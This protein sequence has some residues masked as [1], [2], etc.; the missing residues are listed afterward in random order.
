[1]LAL[2]VGAWVTSA[3]HAQAVFNPAIVDAGNSAAGQYTSMA[4]V[5]GKPAI[6]CYDAAAGDLK[7][8][9]NSAAD[10]SGT[11]IVTTVDTGVGSFVG[12]YTSLAV[13]GGKPA[14]SY[15]NNSNSDLKFA[16]NSAADGSGTWL[17]TTVDNTGGVGRYT[18]L[19]VLAD[20]T[21]AISYSDSTNGDLK[22]AR[23]SAADGSGAWTIVTVDNSAN[24]V[25]A[26]TSLAIVNGT[27]AISYHDATAGDLKF[28]RNS[29]ADGSGAWTIVTVDNSANFVGSYTSLAVIGGNPAISYYDSSVGELKYAW[30]PNSTG[31]GAWTILSVDGNGTPPASSNTVGQYTSLISLNGGPAISYY[32]TTTHDLKIARNSAAN[33]SGTW[34]IVTVESAGDVGSYTSLEIIGGNPAISHHDA[35]NGD[36][37]FGRNSAAD[38]SGTWSSTSIEAGPPGVAGEYASQAVIGGNPAMSYYDTAT[39]DLKFAR[40]S[41]ADGS[42]TWAITGVDG[43]GIAP[44]T[45]NTVGLYTSLAVLGNGLPAISYNN[46]SSGDLK[47]ARNSAADGSG[48]WTLSTPDTTGNVGQYT[49]LA[50]VSGNPA[51]TYYDVGNTSLKFARNAAADGSGTWAIATLDTGAVATDV[52]GLYT[53]LAALSGSGNPAISYYDSTNGALKFARNSAADGSGTWTIV[54]VD[55]GGTNDVGQYTSLAIV[56]GNPAISYYDA[57]AGDLKYA[58]NSAADGSGTWTILPVDTGGT[59]DVGQTNSLKVVNGVPAISYYDFTA[60]DLKYVRATNADGT[61]WATPLTVETANTV[62][63][64]SSLA[65]LANG[66]PAIGYWD[67]THG[68]LRWAGAINAAEI[69]VEQ[70]AGTDL[71]DGTS[72]DFGV[73]PLGSSTSL[74]FTLKN[75]GSGPLTLDPPVLTGTRP[76]DFAVNTTGT[77]L[78]IPGGGQTTF[79]VTFTPTADGSRSATLSFANNDADENPFNFF[80]VGSTG[81]TALSPEIAVEQPAGTDLID[82][83]GSIIFETTAVGG[84]SAA[85]VFTVKNTGT[86]PLALDA[87]T[88]SGGNPGDFVVD[89][90]G[91]ARIL[92]ATTGQTTFA[93]TFTP[94]A[95]GTRTTSLRIANNDFN[96]SSFDIALYG[97]NTDLIPPTGGTVVL[98]PASPFAPSTSLNVLFAGWTDPGTPLSYEVLVDSVI[99][100]TRSTS[101]SRTFT[102]P[103]TPGLHTLTGRI[104]DALNNVTE[105]T[106]NFT[107]IAPEIAIEQPAGTNLIDSTATIISFGPGP[108]GSPSAAKIFTVKNTGTAPLT[109]AA[110]VVSGTEASD[111]VVDTTGTLLVVPAG[112]QTTFAITF[113]P[114]AAGARSASVSITNNDT[115]EN[116]FNFTV[117]GTGDTAPPNNNF[118]NAQILPG[119]SGTVTGGNAGATQESGEPSHEPNGN[120]GGASVWYQW[121]APFTGT[122]TIDTIGSNFDTILGVYT[123]TA[124]G[125]LTEVVKDDDSGGSNT[126][127]VTFNATSGTVYRIA[128]DGFNRGSGPSTGSITL[129]Y[130]L[131]VPNDNFANAQIL[132]GSSGTVTG[133]NAGATQEAGEPFTGGVSVWYQ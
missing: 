70:P 9:R 125:S 122:A 54:T 97:N 41:A 30:A 65:V 119:S 73:V 1:M 43:T 87:F 79:S 27:P 107:V 124:V 117:T 95:T 5:A 49:S 58:R 77:L 112:G 81:S 115:N 84:S 38:G 113:T 51:I 96:E 82:G 104:Y 55:T 74:T 69:A 13:V 118:A 68:D 52:V 98:T 61:A 83:A 33:G 53:S 105:V 129:N 56:N 67:F 106:Q 71:A 40:N 32:D 17:L 110:P 72:K 22:F 46:S 12:E 130:S 85:K 19:A 23:N 123:G 14:I 64:Y 90:A 21:P 44:A 66:T 29:A 7:F 102:G 128:V 75:T 11:W 26:H 15:Y 42:G 93:V 80:P 24:F 99:R 132:P 60:G 108:V 20:G 48:T 6:S 114:G 36:L 8:A 59:N 34:T 31:T 131:V 120:P 116:P 28:A 103:A 121:T 100:A 109:L 3:A 78:F 126:S 111:F 127:K 47:F 16:I 18:S 91:T 92:P 2:L 45:A 35:T 50:V 89:L 57:T 62:G 63:R 101:T 133:G 10:G 88:F 86:A 37:K 94:T 39:D 4:V 76:N 25:G